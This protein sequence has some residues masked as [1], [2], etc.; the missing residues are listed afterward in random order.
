[1]KRSHWGVLALRVDARL[2]SRDARTVTAL[3]SLRYA[4]HASPIGPITVVESDRGVLCVDFAEPDPIALARQLRQR[5]RAEVALERRSRLRATTEI[6]EY[7]RRRRHTFSAPVDLRLASPFQRKV[8]GALGGVGFG[9][10][11]TYGDLA[12][13]VGKPKAAR[14]IGVAMARNPVP[15]LVPC[16]RVIAADGSLGGFSSGLD[17]KR[18]L[19]AHEGIAPLTGGWE[20][21]R[22][23]AAVR[24]AV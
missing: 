24:D 1:M 11:V 21:S 15:I 18:R 4:T 20:P 14:A 13:R 17:V 19:H 16:H 7:F 9:E 8:F 22:R 12:R 23:W 6:A 5:L 10:I 3:L 2:G